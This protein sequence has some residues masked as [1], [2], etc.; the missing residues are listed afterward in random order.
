MKATYSLKKIAVC[1][2]LSAFSLLA[3]MLENLFPP[4][5]VVGG[6]LGISNYFILI[7]G[8]YA[9]FWYGAGALTVKSILGSVFSGNI[10]AML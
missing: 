6:R 8:I 3:F 10:G 5:F 2:V 9:G 7:A 4:L 1:G